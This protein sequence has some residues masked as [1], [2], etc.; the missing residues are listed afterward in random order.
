MFFLLTTWGRPPIHGH[1]SSFWPSSFFFKWPIWIAQF[2][3]V[4]GKT[5]PTEIQAISF[6]VLYSNLE[7]FHLKQINKIASGDESFQI[8]STEALSAGDR[9]QRLLLHGVNRKFILERQCRKLPKCIWVREGDAAS[10]LYFQSPF[11]RN[12]S[13]LEEK[14]ALAGIVVPPR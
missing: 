8:P 14:A 1:D 5:T 7:G 12:L 9:E 2:C 13:G 6:S 3:I 4:R 10:S 11:H